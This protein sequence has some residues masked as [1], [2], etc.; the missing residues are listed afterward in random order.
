MTHRT[1]LL[2]VVLLLVSTVL[3][4]YSPALHYDFIGLDDDELVVRNPD[5]KIFGFDR[6]WHLVKRHYITLYVPVTML[7]YALDY[8]VWHL[9]P[10]GFRF[11]NLVI[12]FFN[13]CL[14][15]YLL[16]L[17]QKNFLIA[18]F[19]SFIF[20]IHPVQIE[21]VIW[22]AERK[23]VLSTFFL[24]LAIV[25]Y[26]KAA[27]NPKHERRQLLI[28]LGFFVLGLLSKPN[29]VIFILI[30]F[31]INHFLLNGC[32]AFRK[33]AWFYMATAI[34]CV[35]VTGLTIFGTATDVEIYTYH[36]GSYLTNL[37]VMMTVFWKYWLLLLF[38]HHQNI[39]YSSQIYKSILTL[40]V[41]FSALSL[42]LFFVF[43][44]IL[45]KRNKQA[46][47]WF[48]W[49]LV[50]LIPVSNLIAPLPSIMN[51]R[52]LYVPMIG[53]FTAFFVLLQNVIPERFYRGSIDSRLKYAGMTSVVLLVFVTLIIPYTFLTLQRIPDWK[54]GEML[55]QS[56]LKQAPRP[57]SRIYYYYA[58]NQLD[59]GKY[60]RSVEL[61]KKALS[62]HSSTD[63]LLALGT[64][65][66]AAEK[67]DEAENYLKQVIERDPKRAGAYDQLAVVYRKTKRFKE[68]KPLHEKAIQLQPRNA[69]LYN[70]YALFF[71]DIDQPEKARETWKY[72]LKLDPDCRLALR[73]LVWYHYLRT[74]WEP[75]AVYLI[76][77]LR[78][79]P[80]DKQMRSLIPLIGT[81]LTSNKTS[82][83]LLA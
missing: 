19:V 77:Y 34:L 60:E 20:V 72:A 12:H 22:I 33:R 10:F 37:F 41:L 42:V 55:W 61:F 14:V 28:T 69:V 15:F 79:E 80:N 78:R 51:D 67:F 4:I 49:F 40:P 44:W 5:I 52:Y 68:A 54:T 16:Y 38:P 76:R 21:S 2:L 62:L 36:G 47:F 50:S 48:S 74:E 56:A 27:T 83:D 7:S 39:L 29:V 75:A 3:I 24:L 64:A 1:K 23:N 18:L 26:W 17:I 31:L 82:L 9:T 25:G 35:V 63:A 59:Q 11:T 70:N 66:V 53:F 32:H 57:D 6:I 43:L 58:I 8:Q 73:N 71:M 45:N 65:C 13:A 46:A 30:I 81:H